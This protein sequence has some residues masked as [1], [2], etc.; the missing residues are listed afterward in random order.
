[1]PIR[2]TSARLAANAGHTLPS[3]AFVHIPTNALLAL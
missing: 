1:M 2:A 3:L